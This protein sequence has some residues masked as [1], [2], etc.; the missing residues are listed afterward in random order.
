VGWEG[1]RGH[2]LQSLTVTDFHKGEDSVKNLGAL[3]VLHITFSGKSDLAAQHQF[4]VVD[5]TSL[6]S[7]K[8]IHISNYHEEPSDIFFDGETSTLEEVSL[9]SCW[10]RESTA[11]FSKV[12][13]N[14]RSL[15][16]SSI[17]PGSIDT[18]FPQVRLLDLQCSVSAGLPWEEMF[19]ALTHVWIELAHWSNFNPFITLR[20]SIVETIQVFV[21]CGTNKRMKDFSDYPKV[22]LEAKSLRR[23]ALAGVGMDRSLYERLQSKSIESGWTLDGIGGCSREFKLDKRTILH[24]APE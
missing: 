5:L 9:I 6:S 20:T 19:P 3:E 8:K 18:R 23:L 16:V 4:P 15:N 12:D 21:F 24:M 13:S 2:Q 22:L 1:L 11:I 17:G 7:L 10:L 14:I